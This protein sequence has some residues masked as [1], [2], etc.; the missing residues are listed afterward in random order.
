LGCYR[1]GDPV[2][3]FALQANAQPRTLRSAP[4]GSVWFGEPGLGR[5]GRIGL[6][7]EV[8]ERQVAAAGS[9]YPNWDVAVGPDGSVWYG[10]APPPGNSVARLRPDGTV[11]N[12]PVQSGST[13]SIDSHGN[14]WIP[15]PGLEVVR[16]SDSGQVA[17]YKFANS[18][19]Q[20]VEAS[21]GRMWFLNVGCVDV[22]QIGWID[23]TGQTKFFNAPN[24]DNPGFP[25]SIVRSPDGAVW[26]GTSDGRLIRLASETDVTVYSLPWSDVG[27]GPFVVLA[28]NRILMLGHRELLDFTPINGIKVAGAQAIPAALPHVAKDVAEAEAYATAVKETSPNAKIVLGQSWEG[29]HAALFAYSINPNRCGYALLV[30]VVEDSGTWRKYDSF[31]TQNV[32]PPSPGATE[33]LKFR[34]GCLNVHQSPSLG[35]K[36]VS[37]LPSGT[38][39]EI[40]GLPVYADGYVWWHLVSRGWAAHPFL[41]CTQDLYATRPEC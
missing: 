5:L 39:I 6:D 11:T 2:E 12:Y 26:F 1:Q 18:I 24:A 8:T 38:Q 21:D 4:D 23:A 9:F 35:S 16:I 10:S 32:G 27:L 19:E 25:N 3:E 31:G 15:Q 29:D 13:I 20:L 41:Y 33:V 36:V 14:A 7:G 22:Q 17:E 37:C 30:Y 34:T 28:G 40:D